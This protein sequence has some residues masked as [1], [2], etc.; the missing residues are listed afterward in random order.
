MT[1]LVDEMIPYIIKHLSIAN[2][3][4]HNEETPLFFGVFIKMSKRKPILRQLRKTPQNTFYACKLHVDVD[5]DSVQC[6]RRM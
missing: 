4:K 6:G 2:H 1:H 3:L 5:D